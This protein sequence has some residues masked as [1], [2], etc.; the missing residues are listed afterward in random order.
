[1]ACFSGIQT[2]LSKRF[3]RLLQ[4]FS[5]V[6]SGG[7][8]ALLTESNNERISEEIPG[9]IRSGIF[10]G[11]SRAIREQTSGELLEKNTITRFG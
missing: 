1:M 6:I 11:M 7:I 5:M 10:N 3:P 8:P 9:N 2:R 4:D